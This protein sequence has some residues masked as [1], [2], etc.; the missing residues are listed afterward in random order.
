M[1]GA[2]GVLSL[3]NDDSNVSDLDNDLVS[4]LVNDII[5]DLFASCGARWSSG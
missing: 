5:T 2:D 1:F 4:K 3:D